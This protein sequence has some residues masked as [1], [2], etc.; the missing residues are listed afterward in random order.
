MHPGKNEARD[1]GSKHE[2]YFPVLL[3]GDPDSTQ[4]SFLSRPLQSA[5]TLPTKTL[6]NHSHLS[7]FPED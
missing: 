6:V 1:W 2:V 7:L 5:M 3:E 4:D